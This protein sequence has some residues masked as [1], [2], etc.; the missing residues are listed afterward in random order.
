MRQKGEKAAARRRCAGFPRAS[1]LSLLILI[2]ISVTCIISAAPREAASLSP[3]PLLYF[4]FLGIAVLTNVEAGKNRFGRYRRYGIP[5]IVGDRGMVVGTETLG[6]VD[7]GVGGI[8]GRGGGVVCV[9][10]GGWTGEGD[11]HTIGKK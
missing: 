9:K 1:Y 7:G 10:G 4:S 2:F 6:G 5:D 8:V 11:G 3:M